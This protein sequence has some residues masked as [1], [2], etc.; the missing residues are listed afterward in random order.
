MAQHSGDDFQK[1]NFAKQD[2]RGR[3]FSNA[4]LQKANFEEAILYG[5]NFNGANLRG[6]NFRLAR[7]DKAD[8]S[9]AKIQGADFHQAELK[10]TQFFNASIDDTTSFPSVDFSKAEI[11]G[12]NFTNAIL[13]KAD[14]T[15]VRAG[16]N[17]WGYFLAFIVLMFCWVI[18]AFS[19][20]MITTFTVY[21]HHKK[22][23][24][25]YSLLIGLWSIILT[26]ILRTLIIKRDIDDK[27]NYHNLNIHVWLGIILIVLILLFALLSAFRDDSEVRFRESLPFIGLLL[28]FLALTLHSSWLSKPESWLADNFIFLEHVI[29]KLG[30]KGTERTDGKWLS[31]VL[32][33]VIGAVF[34]CIFA[35]WAIK[36]NKELNWLWKLYVLVMS[37]GGTTFNQAD[38]TNAVFI[39][40]SLKGV[41]FKN[42]II[43]GI[44]WYRAKSLECACVGDSYLKLTQVR[45]LVVRLDAKKKNFDNLNLEG[46]N[47]V[48]PH[49]S[50]AFDPSK[51]T[52]L[53]SAS[54]VG[55]NLNGAYLQGVNLKEANLKQAKLNGANLTQACL[56]GA[57]IEDWSID[58]T[59]ILRNVKCEYVFQKELPDPISGI[60]KRLP[61]NGSLKP[62]DLEKIFIV[63]GNTA[64]LLIRQDQNRQAL[65][66]A[67]ERLVESN[68]DFRPDDF[69]GFKRIGDDVLVTIRIPQ[70]TS[71][72]IIEQE[73]EQVYQ[74]VKQESPSN[75]RS[76]EIENQPL[77][78]FILKLI[79][80]LGEYMSEK[81]EINIYGPHSKYI[82]NNATYIEGD[83]INMSQDLTKA[84]SQIQDLLE[85]LQ[86]KP[87]MT[88][89][90]AEQEVA[91]DIASLAKSNPAM[92]AKLLKWG[93]SLGDAT[94]NDVVKGVVKLAIRSA[95]FPLP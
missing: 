2:L 93:Q 32:G 94:I 12:A 36:E 82:E 5:A 14:F 41:N 1:A 54:F 61:F 75:S 58:I 48:M 87:N 22:P 69:L 64:Q 80:K 70:Q 3:D 90:V 95:G 92:K 55:A 7:L 57:T 42:A 8:F 27:T 50:E 62:G 78:E 67:F 16:L 68:P 4:N 89:E 39:S 71:G 74:Q 40:A 52:N 21:F 37:F 31:G 63:E 60:R 24:I 88:V 28:I 33:A 59:T 18:S 49:L 35:T 10:Y 30:G 56:T 29:P 38:L 23:S 65:A 13:P 17:F 81:R 11:Q 66:T 72:G 20:A 91:E 86:K 9:N 53:S 46:I 76:S 83:Y 34:G 84:A 15:G 79:K 6:A 26:V 44:V 47:L 19:S 77:F 51:H 73:F 43:E 45:E 25:S 85:H